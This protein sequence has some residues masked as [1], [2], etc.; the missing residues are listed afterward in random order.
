[1]LTGIMIPSNPFKVFE[2]IDEMMKLIY[3]NL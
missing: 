2:N 1:M 3:K